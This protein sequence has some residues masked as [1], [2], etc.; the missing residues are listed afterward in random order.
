VGAPAE[1]FA[2]LALRL[3]GRTGMTQRDLARRLDVH[4][5]S[6]Q[7]WEG[8]ASHPNARRLQALVEVF[9]DSNAFTAG[10]ELEEAEALWTAA[11]NESTRLNRA[12]DASWFTRS[13]EV[14]AAAQRSVRPLARA[15]ATG[16]QAWGNAPDV[17]RF[18]SREDERSTIRQWVLN[19]RCRLIGVFGIGGIG[20]TQLATRVARD[21]ESRFQYVYWR[22]LQNAP[23]FG[24][25][26]A[27]AFSVFSP[28]DQLLSA[29]DAQRFDRL[30]ELVHD[31]PSLLIIDN[32]ETVLQPGQQS[33]QY[34]PGYS[35]YGALLKLLAETPHQACVL[36]TSREEPPELG[37]LKGSG[38][39]VRALTLG[40]LGP[41]DVRGLLRDKDLQ[42]NSMAW[43]TLVERY[44]GNGLAL[45][46]VG[47]TIR[48]LFGGDIAEFLS[49]AER[50]R[51]G[52]V[53]GVRQLL[54][55][56]MSRLSAVEQRVLRWMAVEREAVTFA[57]LAAEM[58]TAAGRVPVR[59]ATVALLRRSL[60]ER[61]EPGPT[62]LLQP[63]ILEY[64]TEQVTTHICRALADGAGPQLR[65]QP[66]LKA[67]A[68]DV[69]RRGQERLILQPILDQLKLVLG[70][71]AAV[72]Q[73][74]VEL[75][76]EQR[77][78]TR[79]EQMYGPGNLINLL[80]LLRG[81]LRGMDLSGLLV[82]QAYLQGVEAQDATLAGAHVAECILPEAFHSMSVAL[83]A[84][85][86]HMV[87]G[88][89]TGDVCL[90][91]A[92][93]R[94]LLLS[95]PGHAGVVWRVGL[96]AGE[97]L[98]VSASEDGT[99][100]V[101]EASSGEPLATL[102][103]HTDFVQGVALSDHDLV[104]TASQDAT[105]KVWHALSGKLL[106]T[107]ESPDG[108]VL[109]VEL[110]RDGALLA[111][112]T[113]GGSIVFWDVARGRLID[114]LRGHA[115]SVPGLALSG[116]DTLLASA[117]LDGTAKLWDVRERR[118]RTEL[119]GHA[120]GIWNISLAK[121]GT[122]AATAGQDGTV[123][124]WSTDTGELLTTI[125]GHQGAVW[126]V[127]LSANGARVASAGQ[128][129]SVRLTDTRTGA[130]LTTL[131]GHTSAFRDVA[132]SADG[133][134]IASGSQNGTVNLWDTTSGAVSATFQA[135]TSHASGVALS[136]DGS[137]LASAG[138]DGSVK[139]WDVQTRRLRRTLTGHTGTVWD[140]ALSADGRLA[141]SGS[142][143]GTVKLWDTRRGVLLATLRGHTQGVR[144][145]AL[146][147]ARRL[148]VS[149][150]QDGS[151]M[152]WDAEG[153]QLRATLRGHANSVQSVAIDFRGQ[154]VASAGFDGAV[155]VWDAG[156]GEC[157]RTLPAHSGGALCVALSQDGQLL[158]TGGFDRTIKVWR[159]NS[160]ALLK[161]LSGH[162]GPV[163]GVSL[164]ADS[165]IL[166]SGSF[167]GTIKLW[168]VPTGVC[169]RT[170]QLDRP[171]ERVDITGLTGVTPANR[172]GLLAL[173]AGDA[174]I[175]ATSD[176]PAI[177]T[178]V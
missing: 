103:G 114:S 11:L 168:T 57:E 177:A 163:W 113:R 54:D 106:Q 157:L 40:G 159:T 126:D 135:H 62:F 35:E 156:N 153:G 70:S 105:L 27:G 129:G 131:E 160:G 63:V 7:L 17:D 134:F 120:S 37:P 140:V 42:G 77:K 67:T 25:W 52:V 130:L 108:G 18:L 138:Q 59:E 171:F 73:R 152:L 123:R 1:R 89:S 121:V 110:S 75:L 86:A 137:V 78:L 49:D 88:T 29:T 100:R 175:S 72:E 146:N 125:V 164:D 154:I 46:V 132:L 65:E 178:L 33:G 5:R 173:G 96:G 141:A 162:A 56:Q 161:T 13:L 87:T 97:R 53:G 80:R 3:R 32:F 148:I 151:I 51:G 43:S 124:L 169:Q 50:S 34:L 118:L 99:A 92:S 60:L 98:L 122:L 127:S 55:S 44:G 128:D 143:D 167:D 66:L 31:A 139:I 85:G 4:V 150:S 133:R 112:G 47:E 170:L 119:I 38:G 104:A 64:V 45:K 30:I 83:S 144:G 109:S 136:Q 93:D 115:A 41:D 48:E 101:W 22:S 142:Y 36:L 116:D 158:V 8:A 81:N 111:G 91:R 95:M 165:G 102:R 14:R 147:D 107:F 68:T 174:A 84:D 145:V 9:L 21:L 176:Q 155:K 149:G 15:P 39:P 166:A 26:L 10:L 24:D 61:S 117:S 172:A 19:D 12:F 74:L 16:H 76:D 2:G 90:R 28:R 6:V 82:R 23:S 79:E 69:V 20:K 94:A 58:G 71:Q